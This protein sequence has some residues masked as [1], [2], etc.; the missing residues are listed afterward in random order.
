MLADLLIL[1][2]EELF[3]CAG[4][5]PRVG[6]ALADAGR[7]PDGA[8]AARDGSVVFVGPTS[9]CERDVTP[10]RD[11]TVLDARGC[12]VIPGF[13]DPHTHLVFAGDRRDELRQRL[14]GASYAEIAAAGGGIVSTVRATRSA[15]VQDLV[16]A[17]LPRLGAM[18]RC[19]TTTAEVKSGYGLSVETELT[20]LRAVRRLAEIQPIELVATFL[21]AHEVPVEFRD[22]RDDYVR[23][24]IEEMI[25]AVAR[26]RL[27]EWCDV[28]CERGVFTPEESE[29]ILQAGARAGLKPRIHANE[30]GSTGGAG[31]A[32]RV[33]AR[34]ADHLVFVD[35]QDARALADAG[36]VAT[37]LPAAA[38]YLKIGRLA[39]ARALVDAG[40]AVALATDVNP[41]GG[42]TPSMPFVMT[43]ACF[44]MG[45]TFDEA[46]V[47]ST[48]N[49]A[50]AL[51][52]ADRV[53]SLEIGRQ[54]DAVIVS[55]PAVGLLGVGVECIRSV[56]KRGRIVCQLS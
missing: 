49:A 45:L 48:L 37:L 11:A 52:R 56:I 36:V 3:T 28:F 15:T 16:E 55:G 14:A 9:D 39:P 6:A 50:H 20:Q 1:H 4:P 54:C 42:L 8:L 35:D 38:F 23:L 5:A 30:L 19:G 10:T 53:G 43:L 27:A 17:A 12:A 24:V 46:L 29:A 44:G 2:A 25:P 21:G 26:E 51:D 31:V 18:L 22:R 40:V 41:G 32:A 47:A 7:I 34:S 13:V 33:G